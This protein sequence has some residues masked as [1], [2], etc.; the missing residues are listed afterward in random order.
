MMSHP[1]IKNPLITIAELKYEPQKFW[2]LKAGTHVLCAVTGEPIPLEKL[3]YWNVERQE[4][5]AD[6]NAS[7][8]RELELRR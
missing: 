1:F 6:A 4:A 3:C 7:L 8:Q 5:Y 2:V